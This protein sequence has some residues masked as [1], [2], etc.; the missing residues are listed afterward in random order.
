MGQPA[1]MVHGLVDRTAK[2][3]VG[4]SLPRPLSARKALI[5]WIALSFIGWGAV[6]GI[7]TLT[8]F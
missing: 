2:D 3:D 4:F 7:M 1:E 5:V 8:L 6:V